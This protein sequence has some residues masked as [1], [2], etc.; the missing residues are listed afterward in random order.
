MHTRD[1]PVSVQQQDTQPT[2]QPDA[3]LMY[4]FWNFH[5]FLSILR[6]QKKPKLAWN[7]R[8]NSPRR[9]FKITNMADDQVDLTLEDITMIPGVSFIEEEVEKLTVA[10][11]KFQLKCRR[12]NQSGT[13]KELLDRYKLYIIIRLREIDQLFMLFIYFELKVYI[14]VKTHVL[15][16]NLL[17]QGQEPVSNENPK[18]YDHDRERIFTI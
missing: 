6:F 18:I 3:P 8:L 7:V 5:R 12:I 4:T 14:A 9:K 16:Q 17:S 10:Q 13:K 11:L 2:G 15:I 1:S